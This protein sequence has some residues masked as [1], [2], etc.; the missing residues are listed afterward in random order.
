MK[1]SIF[2]ILVFMSPLA[3]FTDSIP[4]KFSPK[5]NKYSGYVLFYGSPGCGHCRKFSR[6]MQK[7]GVPFIFL[8]VINNE[9]NRNEMWEKVR[10]I[11][12]EADSVG[13]PVIDLN[14][15]ILVTPSYEEFKNKLIIMEKK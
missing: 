5:Q 4:Q 12:P 2:I 14:G 1:I 3:I 10:T 11:K 13:F 15:I 7:E 8:N 9:N 6:N